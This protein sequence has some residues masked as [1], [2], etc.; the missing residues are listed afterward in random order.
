MD[1]AGELRNSWRFLRF[2]VI[3]YRQDRC[4]SHAAN[5]TFTTLFAVI[6]MLTV[7]YAVLAVAP[8]LKGAGEALQDFLLRNFVPDAGDTVREYLASFAQQ[9]RK[10]TT[11]GL[12]F[13]FVTSILLMFNVERA[14]ND[15]WR[16]SEPRKG[17]S[18][19]LL[20]WAVLS[21]G[22][23]LMGIGFVLS[24]YLATMP[25]IGETA[26]ELG[27]SSAL[28]ERLPLL[29]SVVAFTL[30]YLVVPNT[31][32]PFNHGLLGGLL[33]AICFEAFK[34]GFAGFIRGFPT[35]QVIYGAFAAV[36]LFL[37][38]V[39]LSWV[40]ILMGAVL[41]RSISAYRR[42][43]VTVPYPHLIG[44]L[45]VIELFWRRQQQGRGATEEELLAEVPSLNQDAWDIY[46][47]FLLEKSIIRNTAEDDFVLARDLNVVSLW[48]LV[49]MMPWPLPVDQD[50]PDPMSLEF[51][52]YAEV[53]ARLADAE[54]RTR[55][56]FG[57]NLAD[58]FRD[59]E[60]SRVVALQ[61]PRQDA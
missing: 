9:A 18:S 39:Y 52:W 50:L 6:P 8:E 33:V 54:D 24:S 19:F 58:L 26:D 35:Y 56:A 7:T 4:N 11:L 23:L 28:L 38:W 3:R 49:R 40:I 22:P 42:F 61:P 31:K 30:L 46:G 60:G 59:A 34:L 5:L 44:V 41:V 57:T 15:I 45:G 20:Y 55:H 27:G 13:L 53:R 32:V 2:L 29:L 48:E 12:T 43:S 51:R 25:F 37:I 17:V 21:L 1:L 14:F 47:S 36:P 10:L 16:V